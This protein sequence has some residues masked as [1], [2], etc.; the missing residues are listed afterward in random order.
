MCW[1]TVSQKSDRAG[2]SPEPDCPRHGDRGANSFSMTRRRLLA[3]PIRAAAR[4]ASGCGT[5]SAVDTAARGDRAR[6]ARP[7]RHARSG[8]R[9]DHARGGAGPRQGGPICLRV[10][11]PVRV[12]ALVVDPSPCTVVKRQGPSPNP[13]PNSTY[14]PAIDTEV[15]STTA[16][17][18][19]SIKPTS[20][21]VR[22]WLT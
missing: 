7:S 13:K 22:T 11:V 21:T 10:S 5:S 2:R 14:A 6:N 12:S 15:P 1:L 20:I 19:R 16:L 9:G 3:N 4:A 8:A 18:P 17:T